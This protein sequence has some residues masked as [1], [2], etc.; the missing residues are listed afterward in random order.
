MSI[1]PKG[2][3]CTQLYEAISPLAALRHWVI[4]T[5]AHTQV[6]STSTW[7]APGVVRRVCEVSC[8]AVPSVWTIISALPV[9]TLTNTAS[10]ISSTDEICQPPKNGQLKR[11]GIISTSNCL[12]RYTYDVCVCLGYLVVYNYNQE[13]C[14]NCMP[15]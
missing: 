2:S 1:G 4:Y 11:R 14:Y 15:M 8:G 10:S 12:S 6:S 7:T 5:P 3:V 13:C 9:T